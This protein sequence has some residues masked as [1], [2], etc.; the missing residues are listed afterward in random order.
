MYE[1]G[2]SRGGFGSYATGDALRVSISGGAV[3]YSRNGVLFYTS[4]QAATYPLLVDTALYTTA[5]TLRE[6]VISGGLADLP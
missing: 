2:T 4:Q 6:V 3:R 1:R 5:A